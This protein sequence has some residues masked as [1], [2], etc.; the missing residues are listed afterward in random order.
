M[1]ITIDDM[2]NCMNKALLSDWLYGVYGLVVAAATTNALDTER[3]PVAVCC[4]SLSG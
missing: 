3:L 1:L 2:P 4:T